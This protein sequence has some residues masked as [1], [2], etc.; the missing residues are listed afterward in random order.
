MCM[1]VCECLVLAKLIYVC[2]FV[3]IDLIACAWYSRHYAWWWCGI[4]DRSFHWV[5][6]K[7]T[8]LYSIKYASSPYNR[9]FSSYTLLSPRP[10][11]NLCNNVKLLFYLYIYYYYLFFYIQLRRFVTVMYFCFSFMHRFAKIKNDLSSC[12]CRVM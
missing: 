2:M 5:P 10:I 3:R 7:I 6:R 4:H 11:F 12:I 9:S 8:P 1:Y